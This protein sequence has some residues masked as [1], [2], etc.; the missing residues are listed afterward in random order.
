MPVRIRLPLSGHQL[1]Y[2]QYWIDAN[3]PV[4]VWFGYLQS[5]LRPV[6]GLGVFASAVAC[7]LA[8]VRRQRRT[9]WLIAAGAAT[10]VL[11]FVSGVATALLALLLAIGILSA[12]GDTVPALWE[13]AAA[14]LERGR[15]ARADG[16]AWPQAWTHRKLGSRLLLVF[17]YAFAGFLLCLAAL[18]FAAVLFSPLP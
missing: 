12:T 3:A 18:R 13:G 8:V 11:V 17:G 1:T 10:A 14:W 5:W 4:S 15:A 16:V 7:W 6:L 2:R 9:A